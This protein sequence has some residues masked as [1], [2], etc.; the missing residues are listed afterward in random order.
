MTQAHLAQV[1]AAV[2]AIGTPALVTA[3]VFRIARLHAQ[4][5]GHVLARPRSFR[6]LFIVTVAL[7][8]AGAAAAALLPAPSAWMFAVSGT[9][10][11]MASIFGLRALG[12]VDR[13]SRPT[14]EISAAS[15]VA[16][17]VPRRA[18]AYLPWS[19]RFL[20][21]AIVSVGIA[22]FAVRAAAP[23]PHRH[24]LVPSVFAFAATM[25]LLL[26]ESWLHAVATGPV[27]NGDTRRHAV[28]IRR[29]FSAELILVTVSLGV[30]HAVLNLDWTTQDTT[31]A[32]LCFAGGI[33][34]IA[35]CALALAS[36]F[37]TTRYS[38]T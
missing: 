6:P 24:M 12:D 23:V 5:T 13:I 31:G 7:A 11:T 3:I 37:M 17:L 10:F 30:A 26:Y 35:G 25:F 28:V 2:L 16:S 8:L 20:A 14:R 27:V 33:V 18:S 22:V 34:G 15:R 1:A 32:W 38:M 36:G 21:Y 29:I 4:S 9:G 19:R